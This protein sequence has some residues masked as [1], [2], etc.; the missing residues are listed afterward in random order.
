MS[1]ER[2][3]L[4]ELIGVS[5]NASSLRLEARSPGGETSLLR[6]AALG[7]AQLHVQ[8]G[9]DLAGPRGRGTPIAAVLAD[10]RR[11][12]SPL[13]KVVSEL[14]GLLWHI[15]YGGQHERTGEAIRLFAT[16]A[17]MR[18]RFMQLPPFDAME[19]AAVTGLLHRFSGRVLHEWLSDR[20]VACG[21]SGKLER[22]ESG[23]WV[24]P[25]GQ[26]KRNATFRVCPTCQGSRRALPS[27]TARRKALELTSEDYEA[28]RWAQH[29]KAG[30]AW[31]DIWIAR[32]LRRP[33][34]VQLE[35]GTKRI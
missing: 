26:M 23:S 17:G 9:A 3:S 30:L 6:V 33:L 28:Q 32:R 22:T 14:A 15:R 25:R 8:H 29:F 10:K 19:E 5:V 27:H 16:Y 24:R 2:R 31:L 20:C 18:A 34:T 7:A 11:A 1:T 21:G 35:R 12:P 13:D 4:Q